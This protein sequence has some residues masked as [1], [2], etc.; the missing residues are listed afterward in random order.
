MNYKL[1][2]ADTD[3]ES[4]ATSQRRRADIQ[5]LRAI[6][7]LGVVAFHAG[8]PIT[9]GFIGVD[10]FFVISGFVIS[11][12]LAN[13]FDASGRVDLKK[14]YIRRF[15]RL[16]PALSVLILLT[17]I[18]SV[19]ILSPVTEIPNAIV[20][21]IGAIFLAA[22]YAIFKT[23]GGYF[24]GPAETNPL[25]H[26]WSLS[27]EEQF[28]LVFP[29]AILLAW[30]AGVRSGRRYLALVFVALLSVMSL[31][32]AFAGPYIL[33]NYSNSFVLSFYSPIG[34][35]WEFGA[36]A[37]IALLFRH[38][39]P[40]YSTALGVAGAVGLIGLLAS[41]FLFTSET[42]WPGPFTLFPVLATALLLIAGYSQDSRVSKILSFR[43]LTKIG[44][45]SYSIYLWH[46]PLIVFAIAL[47]PDVREAPLIAA[48][49]SFI[50]A[51]ASYRFVEQPLR[52]AQ[53]SPRRFIGLIVIPTLLAPI[54]AAGISWYFAEN[55]VHTS[56]FEQIKRAAEDFH[57]GHDAGCDEREPLGGPGQ[58][59]CT[60][61]KS[62]TGMPVYL[63]GDSNAD[64]YIEGFIG[65]AT[66]LGSPLVTATT[67]GC[68][69]VSLYRSVDGELDSSCSDYVQG[70]LSFLRNAPPGIVVISN[71]DRY[72]KIPNI[73][74]GETPA[75]L[76]N[77]AEQ[78]FELFKMALKLD[79][80]MIESFGHKVVLM[81]TSPN[82]APVP[83]NPRDCLR[84]PKAFTKCDVSM[85]IQEALA[86]QGRMRNL[87]SETAELT[88][89][90][91]YDSWS[92]MCHAD[93]CST[94][95]EGYFRYRD[96]DHISVEQSQAL[97]ESI[98]Q[99]L[100]GLVK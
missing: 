51:I 99:F 20:T 66:D 35:A 73:G 27:V 47:W 71:L 2:S 48:L 85:T 89:A 74:L 37:L 70:T 78:K 36:G 80:S 72:W 11:N 91:V 12:M 59:N 94:F 39:K 7:V 8:L 82:W 34:R 69:F 86:N 96:G 45:Y 28:Y 64:H 23:T 65:A 16:T 40:H 6:A 79:T 15:K 57:A 44:D 63:I 42:S 62:A 46:W 17:L 97:T 4:I 43:P 67:S 58:S 68:P 88:G 29:I 93:A 84:G 100:K 38:F 22:N 81:Q 33:T 13:E 53:T 50:P 1:H 3:Q 26:T 54:C 24:D 90:H 18:A 10:V 95:A 41:F 14:F 30:I 87:I 25:L 52:D 5:G 32:F 55:S 56:S 77:D 83:W 98:A 92:Y 60:W 9:G 61:N 75:M 76:S 49:V 21:G 19:A 31:T